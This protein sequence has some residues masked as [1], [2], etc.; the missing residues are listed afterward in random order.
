MPQRSILPRT[1][2]YLS[3]PS[4]GKRLEVE[5]LETRSPIRLP[6][7]RNGSVNPSVH[8]QYLKGVAIMTSEIEFMNVR[9]GPSR[10]CFLPLRFPSP[11]STGTAWLCFNLLRC[12]LMRAALIFLDGT[13]ISFCVAKNKLFT[14]EAFLRS[15][16][17]NS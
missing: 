5:A 10:L 17:C 2:P 13:E 4:V 6:S 9:Y 12:S 16:M 3:E 14:L 11:S 1:L 15:V 8:E 7:L